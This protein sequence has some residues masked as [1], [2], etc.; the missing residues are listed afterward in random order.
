MNALIGMRKVTTLL[1]LAI[2]LTLIALTSSATGDRTT[3][4]LA[5]NARICFV[6]DGQ[7]YCIPGAGFNDSIL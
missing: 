1:R 3:T 7:I 5:D 4:S 6:I 2:V